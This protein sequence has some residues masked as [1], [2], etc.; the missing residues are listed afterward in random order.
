MIAAGENVPFGGHGVPSGKIVSGGKAIPG[1]V[2]SSLVVVEVWLPATVVVVVAV[3]VS[4]LCESGS[5]LRSTS[6]NRWFEMPL[7]VARW[8]SI[9]ARAHRGPFAACSASFL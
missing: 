7:G 4:V 1:G 2:T 5:G 6:T 8:T 3:V 9:T